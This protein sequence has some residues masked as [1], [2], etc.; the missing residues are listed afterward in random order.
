MGI[1]SPTFC[2]RFTEGVAFRLQLQRCGARRGMGGF[3]EVDV[4]A[5][6]K[7]KQVV[8]YCTVS[9]WTSWYAYS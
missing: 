6:H 4:D 5:Q 3:G 9:A 7:F 2:C 8:F 1:Y